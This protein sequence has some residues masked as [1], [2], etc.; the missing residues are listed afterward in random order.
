MAPVSTSRPEGVVKW[1][2]GGIGF[3]YLL[4]PWNL[5]LSASPCAR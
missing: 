3:V 2:G 4:E 1:V 5:C